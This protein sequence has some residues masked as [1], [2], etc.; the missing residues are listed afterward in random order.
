MKANLIIHNAKIY[1]AEMEGASSHFTAIAA[2]GGQ[3]L[4]AGTNE[5]ILRLAEEGAE[6]IDA[7]GCTV[8]PGMCDSHLHV[9]S[10]AEVL[11]SIGIYDIMREQNEERQSYLKRLLAAVVEYAEQH[12]G[13]QVI[14]ATGWSPEVFLADPAGLPTAAELDSVCGDRPVILRSFDH[15][16]LWL[17]SKALTLTGITKNTPLGQ[18]VIVHMGGDGNPSGVFEDLPATEMV[19]DSHPLLDYSKEE[20]KK[21]ILHYQD[22]YALPQGITF[23]FDA[24][25]RPAAL[26]AYKELAESGQ[27][28]IRVRAALLADP[29]K[30]ASQFDRMIEEKEKYDIRDDF[31]VT[32]V[33]FF[34]DGGGFTSLMNEPLNPELL[35]LNGF[36]EDFT[37]PRIWEPEQAKEAFLKV[38]KAGYQ[39]HVHCM[40]DRAVKEALD[41]FE[42]VDGQGVCGLRHA[43][44]HI[45]LIDD[46]DMER[47]ARLGIVA[48]MQ[49]HW[50][51]YES[52][53]ENFSVPLFG[54]ERTLRSY[55]YGALLK[56]GVICSVAT[57]F[58]I[59]ITYDT[60]GFMQVGITRKVPRNHPGYEKYKDVVAG[61]DENPRNYCVTL[62]EILKSRTI[63]GAYQLFMDDEVGSLRAGKSADFVLLDNDLESLDEMDIGMTNVVRVILRG[64]TIYNA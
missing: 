23:V 35:R 32:T 31:R 19:I 47:M 43:I 28:K 58:P 63:C 4:A 9:S 17:N 29:S 1:S 44:T 11:F 7:G 37:G 45:Q 3:I 59:D 50:G 41:A 38:A 22:A 40:G 61:P 55:P 53:A 2:T 18:G 21:G 51:I 34:F 15:H 52:F 13:A 39:I 16:L 5:E 56:A 12:P 27:I 10:T 33:K 48:S 25:V 8:L 46:A 62:D 14:R 49:A 57:D 64:E 20:Y 30:P 36:S 54:R 24:F 42:Y 6:V 60:F 26:E